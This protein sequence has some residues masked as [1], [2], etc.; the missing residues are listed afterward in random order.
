ME[1]YRSSKDASVGSRWKLHLEALAQD[2][3]EQIGKRQRLS[4]IDTNDSTHRCHQRTTFQTNSRTSC[5]EFWD[6]SNLGTRYT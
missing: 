6:K 3:N 2:V 1:P 5:R 4:Q